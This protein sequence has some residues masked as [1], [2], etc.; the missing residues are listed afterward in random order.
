MAVETEAKFLVRDHVG[1]QD[2]KRLSTLGVFILRDDGVDRVR[3]LY[4]DTADRKLIAM[5]YACRLRERDC[6]YF[7]TVKSLASGEGELQTRTEHEER[8]SDP[9]HATRP[10]LWPDGPARELATRIGRGV[11]LGT[12]CELRQD[13]WRR[14][15]IRRGVQ[16][17]LFEMSLDEVKLPD[18]LYCLEIELLPEGS[19]EELAELAAL[20]RKTVPLQADRKSKLEH[21]LAASGIPYRL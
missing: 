6:E 12:L 2:L 16:R 10:E 18:L 11:V 20:L 4:M 8:I 5:G 15:V 7:I 9:A 13:R 21:A 14:A 17:P 1:F 3:D 19:L